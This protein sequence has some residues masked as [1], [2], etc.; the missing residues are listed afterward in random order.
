[1]CSVLKTKQFLQAEIPLIPPPPNTY[2]LFNACLVSLSLPGK[3]YTSES[4]TWSKPLSYSQFVVAIYSC[5]MNS[6]VDS[7]R[8]AWD[9]LLV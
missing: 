7:S 5:L 4:L 9:A 6:G 3:L 1:M 8:W 2:L